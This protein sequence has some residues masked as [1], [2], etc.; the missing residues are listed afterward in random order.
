MPRVVQV[1]HRPPSLAR[2]RPLDPHRSTL[3]DPDS[4]SIA[5][6]RASG[7]LQVSLSKVPRPQHRARMSHCAPRHFRST[8]ATS[9]DES[10]PLRL[11]GWASPPDGVANRT[12]AWAN[13]QQGRPRV[14][15][16]VRVREMEQHVTCGLPSGHG[17][18]VSTTRTEPDENV[19]CA[20]IPYTRANLS[21]G[22]S[23]RR[24]AAT[25]ARS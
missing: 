3:G 17:A 10:T 8:L 20:Y 12:R 25:K 7:F 23:P 9:P 16:I 6:R 14:A 24:E 18:R 11:A 15:S 22:F 21:A 2:R 5:G 13:V 1:T 4:S 19:P